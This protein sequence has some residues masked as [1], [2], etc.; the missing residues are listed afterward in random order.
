[1]S[2]QEI[3]NI[4]ADISKE[5]KDMDIQQTQ[6]YFAE[7]AAE[8]MEIMASLKKQKNPAGTA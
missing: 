1:M 3:W 7:G 5:I 6:D 8:A 2:I 4:K